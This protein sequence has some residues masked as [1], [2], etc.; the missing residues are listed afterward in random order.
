[1]NKQVVAR[2]LLYFVVAVSGTFSLLI[3]LAVLNS[4]ER[5]P[6]KGRFDYFLSSVFGERSGWALL[7]LF[8]PYLIFQ[9][10]RSI[11][12]AR[13]TLRRPD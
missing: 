1:M 8:L 11:L 6:W 13:R 7:L 5:N 4:H 9:L 12:W 10:A 2:E 3:L